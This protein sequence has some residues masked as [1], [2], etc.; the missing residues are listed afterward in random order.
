MVVRGARRASACCRA[1]SIVGVMVAA[2]VVPH[3]VF[4]QTTWAGG[5]SANWSIGSNWTNGVPDAATATTLS[6]A[7][8][9]NQ[10]TLTTTSNAG[11]VNMTG[12]T[13]NL[14]G[15]TLN[16]T[17][18]LTLSAG[19]INGGGTL[20]VGSLTQSGGTLSA[21]VTVSATGAVSLTGGSYTNSTSLQAGTLSNAV[22]VT[23]NTSGTLTTP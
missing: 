8:G 6:G 19:V 20:N 11:S 1:C 13:L 10:P 18:A 9:G 23:F 7:G 12:G 2:T 16:V 4:A 17:N 22:G 21:G 14:S 15:Q 5:T 3:A